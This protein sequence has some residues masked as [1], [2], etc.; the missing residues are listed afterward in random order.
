[1]SNPKPTGPGPGT[2][3]VPTTHNMPVEWAALNPEPRKV[4]DLKPY[5]RNTRLHSEEQVAQIA[6][7]M[8]EFGWTIPILVDEFDEIIAGH[9][10]LE[11]AIKIGFDEVP[12]IVARGWTEAQ[13]MAYRIADNQLPMNATWSPEMLKL[14]LGELKKLDFNLDLLGFDEVRLVEFVT[15]V[16][17]QAPGR[18]AEIGNLAAKFGVPPFST[19]NAREG[20]WQNRKRGWL[21]LGIM[22]ELGRGENLL[23]MS[24]T[25]LEPDP[26]KRAAMQ[27]ARAA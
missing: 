8:L 26:K 7:A 11:A 2:K 5:A 27:A 18:T 23:K 17:D 12:V 9:G 25:I 4:V 3:L 21:E 16:G 14:E 6:A 10:R 15:G 20:W 13:K 19:L 24:D 22:S 1:M